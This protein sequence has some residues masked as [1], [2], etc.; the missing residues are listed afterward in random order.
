MIK[1]SRRLRI[2]RVVSINGELSLDQGSE[3]WQMPDGT[4]GGVGLWYDLLV[5]SHED[6]QAQARAKDISPLEW[7]KRKLET[8]TFI[9]V[10]VV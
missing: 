9:R 2:Y 5:P 4:I 6:L 3:V 1:D 8:V 7:L 10:D